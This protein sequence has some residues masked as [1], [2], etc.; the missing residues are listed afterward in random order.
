[1]SIRD[2]QRTHGRLSEGGNITCTFC[3]EMFAS[4]A[5]ASEH[6]VDAHGKCVCPVCRKVIK[7]ASALISHVKKHTRPRCVVCGLV[8]QLCHCLSSA[9]APKKPFHCPLCPNS[10]TSSCSVRRHVEN[11][12]SGLTEGK[13]VL[14][15]STPAPRQAE[16]LVVS[17]PVCVSGSGGIEVE[18]RPSTTPG[19]P[20][21]HQLPAVGSNTTAG[22]LSLE[23]TEGRLATEVYEE[24][25][26]VL[27]NRKGY[28]CSL[29]GKV[30]TQRGT[31]NRHLRQTHSKET[32]PLTDIAISCRHCETLLPSLESYENHFVEEHLQ[33]TLSQFRCGLC[34]V[35]CRT[36]MKLWIHQRKN[37]R[38]PSR[39]RGKYRRRRRR[40]YV[41]RVDVLCT[42]VV[43]SSWVVSKSWRKS[44]LRRRP[45]GLYQCHLCLKR[46]INGRGL[47]R[48]SCKSSTPKNALCLPYDPFTPVEV[49]LS[50]SK[51]GYKC[52]LCGKI[53]TRFEYFR[54]HINRH[55]GI[56]PYQ[57]EK[58]GEV[59]SCSSSRQRHYPHCGR[60]LQSHRVSY[61]KKKVTLSNHSLCNGDETNTT[62]EEEA[63][64]EE[65]MEMGNLE[66]GGGRDEESF[67]CGVCG[68][69]LQQYST[70]MDHMAQHNSS[71]PQT[72]TPLSISGGSPRD[73]DNNRK[74]KATEVFRCLECNKLY[75]NKGSLTKHVRFAHPLPRPVTHMKLRT[76][77]NP[78]LDLNYDTSEQQLQQPASSEPV[79]IEVEEI[80]VQDGEECRV[81]EKKR[82]YEEEVIVAPRAVV[83]RVA[84]MP[85]CGEIYIERKDKEE[86]STILKKHGSWNVFYFTDNP[87]S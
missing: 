17:V 36:A 65:R 50:R 63:C 7:T 35:Q 71:T 16:R 15:A 76:V 54:N 85:V 9:K 48:H 6:A 33:A 87:V 14:P 52:V 49:H 55:A 41:Q 2:D 72:T 86:E 82:A 5:A 12:H 75:T 70:Y 47:S 66:E 78:W 59:F 83:D 30:Y 22:S 69:S 34:G 81:F 56:Y 79:R 19:G 24:C 62:E 74:Q 67:V 42:H 64:E 39:K 61:A 27:A 57:C 58:C 40:R 28:C 38:R 23:P 10:Y 21:S 26:L 4:A 31:L 68:I 13:R 51:T 44:Q 29:C 43:R 1:M 11:H 20:A 84:V 45:R 46:F 80:V 37:H 53:L 73:H 18:R 60:P 3:P 77:S 25:T 8:I 32:T